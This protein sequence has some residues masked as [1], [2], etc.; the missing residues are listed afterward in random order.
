MLSTVCFIMPL[1][2]FTNNTSH[3]WLHTAEHLQECNVCFMF[4]KAMNEVLSLPY[5]PQWRLCWPWFHGHWL[6]WLRRHIKRHS[7]HQCNVVQNWTGQND[8]AHFL[9]GIQQRSPCVRVCAL[10]NLCSCSVAGFASGVIRYSV[11]GKPLSPRRTIPK[12]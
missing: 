4:L 7:I 12:C 10:L 1:A 6:I 8:I 9:W 2:N 5:I 11:R 3:Y